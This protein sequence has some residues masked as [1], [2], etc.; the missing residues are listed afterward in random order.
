MESSLRA[1]NRKL[2]TPMSPSEPSCTQ[3][4]VELV[5]KAKNQ[6]KAVTETLGTHPASL[7]I[8]SPVSVW[9]FLFLSRSQKTSRTSAAD[10]HRSRP[11]RCKSYYLPQL[12]NLSA[13]LVDCLR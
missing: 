2:L 6:T 5:S 9:D 4:K 12:N 7:E 13:K 1:E 3:I 10:L 8:K 11:I